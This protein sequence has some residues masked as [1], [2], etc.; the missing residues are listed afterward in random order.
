MKTIIAVCG[1]MLLIS[2][3]LYEKNSETEVAERHRP[4]P[5]GEQLNSICIVDNN[6]L[7]SAGKNGTIIRRSDHDSQWEAC[8]S[9][10]KSDL[11][12]IDFS[13]KY[14]GLAVG[15]NGTIIRTSNSGFTWLECRTKTS[16]EI[17]AVKFLEDSTAI[18]C[19][20]GGTILKTT[21]SGLTWSRIPTSFNDPLYCI[22][23][24][25]AQFGC[26]G[27]FNSVFLTSDSG[28]T[29]SK[30]QFNFI[31]PAQ[32]TGVCRIDSV[33]IFISSNPHHGRFAASF[34]AG[35]SWIESSLNLPLLYGGAVDLVRDIHFT[36]KY[37]GLAVTEYGTILSTTDGGNSWTRD[38]SFRPVNEK[39]SIMRCVVSSTSQSYICGGGGTI[40]ESGSK[41]DNWRISSGGLN[42]INAACFINE[43]N[44]LIG[45]EGCEIY[46]TSNSGVNWKLA[47]RTNSGNI[48]SM[49]FENL[50]IGYVATEDGIEKTVNAGMNWQI[51][52][53]GYFKALGHSIDKSLLF[54]GGGNSDSDNSILIRSSDAGKSWVN[55]YSGNDG[56]IT[57][58]SVTTD[59]YIFASTT[60]GKVLS[61]SNNGINWNV[62]HATDEKIN[63]VLFKNSS[64][65]I[66]ASVDGI[67]LKTTD[68]GNY[69]KP[70]FTGMSRDIHSICI[71]DEGYAAV[72]E[73][74]YALRST[75]EGETWS[76]LNK[77]TSNNLNSVRA[78]TGG[79]IFC[80]GDFGTVISY[81]LMVQRHYRN[82]QTC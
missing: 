73:N 63:C 52:Y 67:I 23:F 5:T 76:V 49:T 14:N 18:A 78:I 55:S 42:S 72:G 69:W 28:K 2:N 11:N 71:Y 17:F 74:G 48:F 8:F 30:K 51:I 24:R 21:N 79:R 60:F 7:I 13:D 19:G 34:D 6:V 70:V 31:P 53:P 41:S 37:S 3:P 12:S 20:L 29:W 58:M 32:V 50:N 40:F 10:T 39:P 33:T 57:N 65:G 61:S 68:G 80:F 62:S 38:T 45:G 25:D 82:Y 26:A 44:S 27:S 16:R 56:S 46:R 35:N 47:G 43:E 59:G 64:S 54:A 75:D 15:T 66:A 77:V 9:N 36:D 81:D 4:L 22:D 1:F